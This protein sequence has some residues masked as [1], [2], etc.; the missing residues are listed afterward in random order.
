MAKTQP[1]HKPTCIGDIS[2]IR[3]NWHDILALLCHKPYRCWLIAAICLLAGS[4]N[5]WQE[6]KTAK[7]PY[8]MLHAALTLAAVQRAA[9]TLPL[10]QSCS[11]TALGNACFNKGKIKS[12]ATPKKHRCLSFSLIIQLPILINITQFFLHW[13]CIWLL[14][15]LLSSVKEL[16]VEAAFWPFM[17]PLIE[18]HRKCCCCFVS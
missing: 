10:Q 11:F 5:I 17:L 9:K 14:M 2:C 13:N 18:K 4:P 7:K 6:R 3:V 16:C 8:W 1:K 12:R 15:V